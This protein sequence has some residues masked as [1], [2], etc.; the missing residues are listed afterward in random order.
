[1]MSSE[2]VADEVLWLARHRKEDA[3]IL[4]RDFKR[5]TRG[6]RGELGPVAATFVSNLEFALKDE[7][8]RLRAKARKK[9]PKA[10]SGKGEKVGR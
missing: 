4:V 1:M 6:R 3:W 5:L 2:N 7:S 9:K 10:K 8:K